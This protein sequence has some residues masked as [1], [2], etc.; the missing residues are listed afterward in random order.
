MTL[1]IL[2]ELLMTPEQREIS[3]LRIDISKNKDLSDA[4]AE[5]LSNKINTFITLLGDLD[6]DT[7]AYK[8]AKKELSK[9]LTKANI[10][11]MKASVLNEKFDMK[12]SLE[13]SVIAWNIALKKTS[14]SLKQKKL[15]ER[16]A[17]AEKKLKQL[18]DNS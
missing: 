17:T 10:D 18:S 15:K 12:S 9:L 7:P 6:K 3:A 13:N 5:Q 16:I 4:Q 1:R 11:I 14:C 2:L 8:K